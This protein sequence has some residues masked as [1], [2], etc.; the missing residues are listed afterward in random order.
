MMA[1]SGVRISWLIRASMS[2]L[3]LAARSVE[4][5]CLAAIRSRSSWLCDRSRNT[6]KKF[7]PSCA[8]A[9]HGNRQRNDAAACARV[10][11]TSRP[12]SSRLET[13]DD[14][15]LARY[16]NTAVLAFRRKQIG[17]IALHE[18]GRRRWPNSASA[19]RL[20]ELMLPSA[21]NI[22]MPSAVVSR[23]AAS[24]SALAWPDGSGSAT[25]GT[26]TTA[27]LGRSRDCATASAF[28]ALTWRVPEQIRASAES[29]SHEIV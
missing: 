5:P 22:K 11:S 20:T 23:M 14:L 18:L 8:G 4:P 10:P 16:S 13:P 3:A 7:G 9:A 15:T 25:T 27:S 28:D 26:W 6:A 21:S 19:L 2:A 1:L 17:E 29:S 24:S 12:W